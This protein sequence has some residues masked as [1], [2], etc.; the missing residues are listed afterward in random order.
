MLGA[1]IALRAA[2]SLDKPRNSHPS[3]ARRSPA[4]PADQDPDE[5]GFGL[6]G[7]GS[8]GDYR[9]LCQ[10]CANRATCTFPRAPG[11]VWHCEEYE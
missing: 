1:E 8:D 10:D 2:V 6:E 11:G 7:P 5:A 4:L 9:G 3:V